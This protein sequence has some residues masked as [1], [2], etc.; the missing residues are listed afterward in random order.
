M[1]TLSCA[2]TCEEGINHFTISYRS[3]TWKDHLNVNDCYDHDGTTKNKLLKKAYQTFEHC[4]SYEK[5]S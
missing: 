1:C 4:I 5:F 3:G 2:S